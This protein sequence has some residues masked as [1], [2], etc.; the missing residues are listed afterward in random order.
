[1]LGSRAE[2]VAVTQVRDDGGLELGGDCGG[3]EKWSGSA[4][5]LKLLVFAIGQM[6]VCGKERNQECPPRIWAWTAL[7]LE[8][9]SSKMGRLREELVLEVEL[10]SSLL[11]GPA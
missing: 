6:W 2:A 4:Y 1:M 9:P 8:L 7:R 11:P 10:E 3:S 5:I